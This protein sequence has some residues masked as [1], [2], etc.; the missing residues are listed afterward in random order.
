MR[1]SISRGRGQARG[2]FSPR[3]AWN[4]RGAN[5]GASFRGVPGRRGGRGN[6]R[7]RVD[8]TGGT[9]NLRS[10]SS[11]NGISTNWLAKT[12]GKDSEAHQSTETTMNSQQTE[13]A[14]LVN[15]EM[16][17]VAD[18]SN[19][20]SQNFSERDNAK[21]EQKGGQSGLLRGQF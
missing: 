17:S 16:N 6:G 18:G 20:G 12:K 13:V 2:T 19:I 9:P 10:T 15:Q 3:G 14:N 11:S 1:G 4:A 21:M 7:G 8:A 5:R